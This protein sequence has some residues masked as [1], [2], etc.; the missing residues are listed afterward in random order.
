[1][2]NGHAQGADACPIPLG[3][4]MSFCATAKA[5]EGDREVLQREALGHQQQRWREHEDE[6]HE[7]L[8]EAQPERHVAGLERVAAAM[9]DAA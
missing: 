9:P 2:K 3:A 5:D 7:R 1:M 4:T 6:W 8:R